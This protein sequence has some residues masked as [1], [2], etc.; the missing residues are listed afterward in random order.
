MNVNTICDSIAALI[1]PDPELRDD[2]RG[3][4]PV[5]ELGLLYVW[6]A[7]ETVTLIDT[8]RTDQMTLSLRVAYAV[9]KETETDYPLR[10]V[11]DEVA[12]AAEHLKAVVRAN[13]DTAGLFN[14]QVES[15][16][17]EQLKALDV[18]GYIAALSGWYIGP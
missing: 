8:G 18:R 17:Y 6:A 2:N 12:A 1:E 3:R 13:R 5:P 14:L 9:D 11:S 16:D 7:G 4:P 10:S 15:I